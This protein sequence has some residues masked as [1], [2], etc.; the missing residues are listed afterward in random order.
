MSNFLSDHL[1]HRDDDFIVIHKPAGILSVPG[2]G[3]LYDSVLTRLVAIEPRSLLIHRLDRDTSG[4]LVFAL[5][6]AAQTHISK[7]F[8]ARQTDKIYQAV[9][10]GSLTGEGSVDIPVVYDPDRPPLHVVDPS[11][12]KPA[13]THWK[14]IENF[15]LQG[16][17]VTRVELTPITGRSHQLRVH[18]QYL[19]HPIVG[20]TLYADEQYQQL[21]SRLCLHA[22]TLSF[23]H[24][25]TEQQLTFSC[26][27]PF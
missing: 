1:I 5:N 23:Q 15:E 14:V 22:M 18:M 8:Q 7:Q 19:G 21:M 16:Q 2:K 25:K 13:L 11:Y 4:I 26:P 9:V 3:D 20:D 10:A 17:P 27:V 24:P 6:K 12:H